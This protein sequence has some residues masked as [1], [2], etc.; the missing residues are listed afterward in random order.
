VSGAPSDDEV[1]TTWGLVMEASAGVNARLEREMQ[2]E[3]GIP[4]TFFEVLLR[5]GRSEGDGVSLNALAAQVSFSSGGFSRLVDRMEAR[6]LVERRPCPTNRRSTLVAVTTSGRAVLDDAVRVHAD[7]L[8]RHLLDALEP[9]SVAELATT[10]R[11]V[12][13]AL[14]GREAPTRG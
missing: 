8:R 7:G 11:T 2:Q 5:L 9:R 1:I 12:R 4:L 14:E 6:G 13:D 3:L 10:M